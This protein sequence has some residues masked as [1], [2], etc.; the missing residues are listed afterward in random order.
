[1]SIAP[2]AI[3][4]TGAN[5]GLGLEFVKQVVCFTSPPKHLFATCRDPESATSLQEIAKAH[6][7][8]KMM[9]LDIC[10]FNSFNNF[11]ENMSSVLEGEGLNLVLCNAGIHLRS[12]FADTTPELMTSVFTTNVIAPFTLAQALLPLLKLAAQKSSDKGMSWHKAALVNLSSVLGSVENNQ[13]G[14]LYPYRASKAALN[15]VTKNQSIDLKADGILAV[16]IHPG[17]VRT[18]MGGKAAPLSATESVQGMLN[19]F[20]S[21]SEETTGTLVDYTGKVMSW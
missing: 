19:V 12:G 17:W 10:D 9:K 8:V 14:G 18:D 11:K 21:M 3:L 5:R 7:C 1:M 6:S 20:S 13:Q 15:M 2:R 16:A 4:I